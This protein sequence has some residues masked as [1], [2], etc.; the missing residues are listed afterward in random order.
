MTDLSA[1]LSI[2][3]SWIG[4]A[5]MHIVSALFLTV[6]L[7][8][9][10]EWHLPYDELIRLWT[11]GALLIGL[12][13]PLAG[14]LGDRWSECRMMAVFFLVTG[15]G[16]M[17]CG[18][19]EGPTSLLWAL[20]ALGLGSSIYHPVG[21]AWMVKNAVNRGKA[22]GYLGIFGTVG[23]ASAALVA[24]GLT[25][26]LGWR[27]AFL[28]PGAICVGLG[29]L[30]AV[31]IAVGVVEDRKGDLKPQP[32]ASRGDVIR[33]FFVLSVTMVC[34]GLMFNGM[35][36]VLPK[37]FEARL[38][39][40]LGDSTLGVGGLVTAV[41]LVAA[42]PQLI[43]GH[44]ADKFPLKRIYTLC[45]LVQVPMMAAVAVLADLP[46]VGAAAL[47]VIA[48]QVQIPAE[49]LL[50]ARYTPEKHRGLAYGAK[51]IL[52]FGAGP[53]AVQ[54]VAYVYERTGEFV[55]LYVTLS[56]LALIAFLAALLLPADR[57]GG[58]K[59]EAVPAPAE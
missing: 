10:R 27:A 21:M 43:G 36:V 44:L 2:G 37:L 26:W 13:A 22:L 20:A 32:K 56:A 57:D 50:L 8:L 19:T 33:A 30:L 34:A 53:I 12:G 48:S 54:L 59:A 16:T 40:L 45:L 42:L 38:S 15:A 46:L 25:E 14:W 4:H 49:N 55:M 5:L 52:S 35:Q 9:E 23:I 47:V 39:H 41:Y 24:G 18:L 7:A 3:F 11:L 51:F 17:A 28:I 31:L 58:R 6:V 29:V 1:R